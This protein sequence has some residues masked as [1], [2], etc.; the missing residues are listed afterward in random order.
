MC[1]KV[2][3]LGGGGNGRRKRRNVRMMWK[4][5]VPFPQLQLPTLS[6]CQK[7]PMSASTP[8]N[9]CEQHT[10][11]ETKRDIVNPKDLMFPS[12]TKSD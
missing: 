7:W 10:K 5:S 9:S 4:R 1:T 6:G 2:K 12:L 3:L 11:A 8:C